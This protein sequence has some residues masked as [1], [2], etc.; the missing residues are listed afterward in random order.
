MQLENIPLFL[1]YFTVSPLSSSISWYKLGTN[2]IKP[3]LYKVNQLAS[4]D[5][6][7][8]YLNSLKCTG[9]N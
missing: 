9:Q 5:Y 2:Q 8:L 4:A 6:K 7:N 1:P 3:N